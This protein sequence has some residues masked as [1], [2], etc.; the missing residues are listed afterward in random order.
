MLAKDLPFLQETII[1]V[2]QSKPQAKLYSDFRKYQR[3]S[4]NKSFF[5]QVSIS[6]H[7]MCA[8]KSIIPY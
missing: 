4:G 2:R 6:D 5:K 3:E 1:Q 8:H 7:K